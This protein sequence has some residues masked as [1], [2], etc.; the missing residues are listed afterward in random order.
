M[1][2]LKQ[3]EANRRNA[4]RSTGPR[5]LEGKAASCLN[6]L[7]SGI[8]AAREVVL[9]VESPEELAAL[10]AGYYER[11]QPATPEQ[12]CLVDCLVSDEWQLRRFRRIEAESMS[13]SNQRA[14][15]RGTTPVLCSAYFNSDRAFDRL[16]HRVNAT[17]KSYQKTLQLL[18]GLQPLTPAPAQPGATP[19]GEAAMP[20]SDQDSRQPIGFVPQTFSQPESEAPEPLPITDRPLPP[21][22]SQPIALLP[23]PSPAQQL[24]S[25]VRIATRLLPVPQRR[26][27][28]APRLQQ[29]PRRHLRLPVAGAQPQQRLQQRQPAVER[30]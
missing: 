5:T 4:Q 17:R 27:D 12:R 20:V 28:P 1:A 15:E 25:L 23:P 7:G 8:W 14:I 29:L 6:A 13:R 19:R 22:S 30:C 16:Q 10:T 9:P 3:I 24:S 18:T 26:F 2:S 11:F 21:G